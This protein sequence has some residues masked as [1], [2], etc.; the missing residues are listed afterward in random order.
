MR[1][2]QI[3]PYDIAAPGGVQGQV[4]LLSAALRSLGHEVRVIAPCMGAPPAP[5]CHGVGRPVPVPGNGSVARIALTGAAMRRTWAEL[6]GFD[7][8][9][10]HEPLVPGA[11]LA[12]LVR[13]KVP[14]VATFHRSGRSVPYGLA[15]LWARRLGGHISTRCAVSD[16]AAATARSVFGGYFLILP[17]AVDAAFFSKGALSKGAEWRSTP[18]TVAFVG[19]H[20]KRKG[21]EVLLGAFALLPPELGAR[22]VVVGEGPE[23]ERLSRLY[24]HLGAVEWRGRVSEEAKAQVLAESDVVCV[25]SLG[26]ESFGVVLLEAMAAGAAVVASD[27]PSYRSVAE[28]GKEALFFP[29]GDHAAL[30]KAMRRLLGDRPLAARLGEAGRARAGSFSPERLAARYEAIYRRALE[31]R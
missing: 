14:V 30:A 9:H 3:C 16:Q 7:I 6:D 19:R 13:A 20:E 4:L 15:G 28:A 22:L 18:P 8:C 1:I 26:G 23:S 27:L 24:A 5:G 12:A 2:A 31:P 21:L 29:P 25:P 10:V 11:P 17:N